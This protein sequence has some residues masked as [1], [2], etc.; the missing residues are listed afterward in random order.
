MKQHENVKQ[1]DLWQWRGVQQCSEEV[2]VNTKF[3]IAEE[4]ICMTIR[5]LRGITASAI[6]N[7]KNNNIFTNLTGNADA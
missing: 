7:K 3:Y 4:G 2:S 1:P 5:I 6:E